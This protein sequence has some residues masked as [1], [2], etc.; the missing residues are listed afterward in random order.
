[1]PT[2]S[3]SE[4]PSVGRRR[5]FAGLLPSDVE[6]HADRVRCPGCSEWVA[7]LFRTPERRLRCENC[8]GVPERR[9]VLIPL[10]MGRQA[11]VEM[12]Y[13]PSTKEAL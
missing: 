9:T 13:R 6:L 7:R 10:G 8:S 11:G 12:L 5:K 4:A 2:T 3:R 1:M